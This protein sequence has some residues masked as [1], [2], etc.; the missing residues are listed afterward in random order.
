MLNSKH[1]QDDERRW[2]NERRWL[3]RT[4]GGGMTRGDTTTSRGGQ[5]ATAPENER[6]ATAKDKEKTTM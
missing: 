3:R 6:G 2:R 5:E 4:G 1:G